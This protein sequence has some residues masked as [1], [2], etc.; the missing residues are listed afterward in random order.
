MS[1][2]ARTST[3]VAVLLIELV[4]GAVIWFSNAP[5]ADAQ[6]TVSSPPA[7]TQTQVEKKAPSECPK[8]KSTTVKKA[9]ADDLLPI[10]ILIVV[11]TLVVVRLP[12]VELGHSR[13]FRHRRLLNWLPLGLTYSFLYMA[14]YNMK[15]F[16]GIGLT[17]LE[18]GT[19]FG[20]GSAVYG[21][22]FLLR[23]S[24]R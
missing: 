1:R 17:E 24:D 15:Q 4:V 7:E 20:V 12:K 5:A 3:L 2:K 6:P 22:A 14:R 23:P 8:K 11:I 10:G 16:Q 19:V 21:V 18:Y 13:A 9:L